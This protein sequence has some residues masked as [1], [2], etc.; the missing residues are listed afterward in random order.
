MEIYILVKILYLLQYICKL[1]SSIQNFLHCE[2]KTCT[3]PPYKKWNID[4]VM[5]NTYM[6]DFEIHIQSIFFL[7]FKSFHT[8]KNALPFNK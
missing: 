2:K 6:Y 3:P 5:E 7:F 8:F 1:Y 4:M